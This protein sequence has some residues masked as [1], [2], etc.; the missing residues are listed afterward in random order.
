[1]NCRKKSHIDLWAKRSNVNQAVTFWL[2][3]DVRKTIQ[4]LQDDSYINRL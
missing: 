4:L 3:G 1:M 2:H